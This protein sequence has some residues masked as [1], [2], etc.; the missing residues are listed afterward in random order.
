MKNAWEAAR[1]NR[2]S[3]HEQICGGQPACEA[4]CGAAALLGPGGDDMVHPT[5]SWGSESGASR[6]GADSP[7]D[8]RQGD[9]VGHVRSAGH[10]APW[11]PLAFP[12]AKRGTQARAPHPLPCHPAHVGKVGKLKLPRGSQANYLLRFCFTGAMRGTGNPREKAT[13][14]SAGSGSF[15]G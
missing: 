1:R 11:A 2:G 12:T 10:P 13:K 15:R 4:A 6:G 5:H 8:R 14:K 7:G 9:G 3:G